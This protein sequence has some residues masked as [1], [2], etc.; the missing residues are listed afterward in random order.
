M[1]IRGLTSYVS[2]IPAVW[3][4]CTRLS[5]TKLII[6]GNNLYLHLYRSS[7]L[8]MQC[9]GQYLEY[10][11]LVRVFFSM[12]QKNELEAIVVLDGVDEDDLKLATQRRRATENIYEVQRSGSV[13][14]LFTSDVFCQAVTDS[15]VEIKM[16]DF[17]GDRVAARLANNFCC[18]VLS[19][20]SDFYLLANSL[21]PLDMFE[22]EHSEGQIHCKIYHRKAFLRHISLSACF[23]PLLAVLVGNDLT[24][25]EQLKPLHKYI[26]QDVTRMPYLPNSK[27]GVIPTVIEWLRKHSYNQDV[28]KDLLANLTTDREIKKFTVILQK[29]RASTLPLSDCSMTMVDGSA[30]PDWVI[31]SFKMVKFSK[32]AVQ[33]ASRGRVRMRVQKEN[34]SN[35]STHTCSRPIREIM[36]AILFRGTTCNQSKVIEMG[37]ADGCVALKDYDVKIPTPDNLCGLAEIQSMSCQE[38]LDVLGSALGCGIDEFHKLDEDW[39]LPAAALYY[40]SH[41]KTHR[42]PNK[43]VYA[44]IF[45]FVSCSLAFNQLVKQTSY[46]LD[47]LYKPVKKKHKRPNSIFAHNFAE[48]QSVLYYIMILNSVLNFPLPNFNVARIF[49]GQLSHYAA[50][51]YGTY[52]EFIDASEDSKMFADMCQ[53]LGRQP[54]GS[55]FEHGKE[56]RKKSK[57][58]KPTITE[59]TSGALGSS[60]RYQLYDSNDSN[61]DLAVASTSPERD[62]RQREEGEASGEHANLET[63]LENDEKGGQP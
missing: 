21:I 18:P 37:R 16:C 39:R 45:S 4:L 56:K 42:V 22:W 36:Y 38:R 49:N 10:Y 29:S 62:E 27:H 15:G 46:S 43:A 61:V 1:G 51:K 11:Q 63:Y 53:L 58:V 26:T 54:G 34:M 8:D 30:F 2:D 23:L 9:G 47:S 40:W 33:A 48:F 20:D 59:H 41:L 24:S 14:P 35:P 13:P 28:E 52:E 6:D 55:H 31:E 5:N 17:E 12:L 3:T 32:V 57:Y 44:L 7:K 19:N 50:S 25:E 60:T